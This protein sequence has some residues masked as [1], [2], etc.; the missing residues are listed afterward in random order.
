MRAVYRRRPIVNWWARGPAPD[1]EEGWF[2]MIL[3]LAVLAGTIWLILVLVGVMLSAR[4]SWPSSRPSRAR[5]SSRPTC[6][7]SVCSTPT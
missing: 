2:H 5:A 1:E 4:A 3:G 6:P 7:G